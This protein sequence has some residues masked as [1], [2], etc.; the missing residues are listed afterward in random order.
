LGFILDWNFLIGLKLAPCLIVTNPKGSAAMLEEPSILENLTYIASQNRTVTLITNFRG[1]P[2]PLSALVIR[3]SPTDGRVRLCIH[4]RQIVALKTAD[5]A[6]MQSD[7]FAATVMAH[8]DEVDF[9]SQIV[10]LSNLRYVTGSMGK[11]KNVRVQP[12]SPIHAEIITSHGFNLRG[13]I[14]DISLD[15][16]SVRLSKNDLPGEEMLAPQAFVEIKLGLPGSQPATIHDL[17][18]QAQ[19]AYIKTEASFERIG[20]LAFPDEGDIQI[21]RRYIFDRQTEI[22]TEIQEMNRSLLKTD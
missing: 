11:R 22:L 17:S 14:I 4:H 15:G 13:E 19:I 21:I 1:V 5:Q 12:E 8:I 7:L 10:T 3:S 2:I 9:H 6:L 20:L 18:I 16:L